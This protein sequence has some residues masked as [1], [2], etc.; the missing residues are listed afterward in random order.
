MT[1]NRRNSADFIK[2]LNYLKVKLRGSGKTLYFTLGHIKAFEEKPY[3]L[4][5]DVEGEISR[6]FPNLK[7]HIY[8]LRKITELTVKAFKGYF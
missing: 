4:K 8:D 1:P 5:M 6:Y 2:H 3:P 7:R